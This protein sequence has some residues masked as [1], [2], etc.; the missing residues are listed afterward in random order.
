MY[1]LVIYTF[2]TTELTP[3]PG[4]EII[5]FLKNLEKIIETNIKVLD[6]L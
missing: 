5:L 4:K 2:S 6:W 1:V 3:H